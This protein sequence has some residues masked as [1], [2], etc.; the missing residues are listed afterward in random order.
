MKAVVFCGGSGKRM[1][2]LSR[3]YAPK[4]L[5]QSL[6]D[7]KSTFQ[8]T[9]ERAQRLV[10]FENILVSTNCNFLNEILKQ[11]PALNKTQIVCEPAM[12]DVA[13]AVGLMS[14]IAERED[15]NE[16]LLILWSDHMVEHTDLFVKMM[17]KAEDIIKKNE[18]GIVFIGHKPRYPE[19]NLGYIGMGDRIHEDESVSQFEFNDWY[20]RPSKERAEE[21]FLA[22]NYAWNTGY[23]VT[24]PSFILDKF[25]EFAPEMYGQLREISKTYNTPDWAT[26]LNSVYP[27]IEKIAFDDKILTKIRPNEATVLT[28]DFG[29]YDPGSLYSLKSYFNPSIEENVVKGQGIAMHSRDSLVFNEANDKPVVLLGMEGKIVVNMKDVIL[30]VDKDFIPHLKE[31]LESLK[32]TDYSDL[33]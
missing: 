14:S 12:R 20:Y 19:E 4:Q 21:F 2:P 27:S 25:Q 33:L 13:A 1:W 15:G 9:I 18:A 11:A 16:P 7:G 30:V 22:G 29:W 8:A 28:A 17:K 32:E 26:T 3:E 5:N 10:P 24:T 23:F 6:F 31:L